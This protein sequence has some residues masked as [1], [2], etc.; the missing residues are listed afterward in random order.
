M[1]SFAREPHRQFRG[2]SAL[3]RLSLSLTDFAVREQVLAEVRRFAA[4]RELPDWGEWAEAKLRT[5]QR[6]RA[7]LHAEDDH[8]PAFRTCAAAD[9]FCFGIAEQAACCGN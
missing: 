3:L 7:A 2:D 4:H 8:L 9:R 6:L 1:P 5:V